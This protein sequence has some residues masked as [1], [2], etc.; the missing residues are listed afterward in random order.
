MK[1]YRKNKLKYFKFKN[2]KIYNKRS[3]VKKIFNDVYKKY[4]LINDIIS[5]GMHRIWKIRAIYYS[6]IRVGQ[7]ILDL[8]GGTGDITKNCLNLVKNKGTIILA[9]I[10]YFMLNLGRD[11]IRN[12]GYINN[13]YY[14]I[15]DAENLPFQDNTFDCI[16]ISFG[17]R[18]FN[19]KMRVLKSIYR[20]LKLG[21]RLLILEFSLPF[22]KYLLK[23]YDFYSFFI[24]PKIGKILTGNLLN[25]QYLV[26]SIRLYPNQEKFKDIMIRAGF[27]NVEYFNMNDGIVSLHRG[28]KI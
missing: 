9:D 26:E 13:V 6:G 25:Y 19:E 14:I 16:I 21:G 24:L 17:M 11:K 15:A 20:I 28:Y 3:L 4:D 1:Y 27:Y 2:N 12:I 23:I 7:V 18:N 8:A 5:F 22:C 10:N